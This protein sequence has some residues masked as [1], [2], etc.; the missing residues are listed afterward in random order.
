M[1][2]QQKLDQILGIE[3]GVPINFG[4][5]ILGFKGLDLFKLTADNHKGFFRLQSLE[6]QTFFR[7]TD[8]LTWCDGYDPHISKYWLNQIGLR[9]TGDN[10]ILLSIVRG[11]EG[12][13]VANLKGPILINT[14]TMQGTQVALDSSKGLELRY[15]LFPIRTD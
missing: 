15:E 3:L 2:T 14:A 7:V 10:K 12:K 5:R 9:D 13:V 8:P 6:T 11:Y 4:N 1:S